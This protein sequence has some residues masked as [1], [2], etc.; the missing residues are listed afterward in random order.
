[1][2]TGRRRSCRDIGLGLLTVLACK[3]EPAEISLVA[4][5]LAPVT[6][7]ITEPNVD[8][9]IVS[10]ADVHMETA[11]FSDPDPGHQH[12][13]SDWAISRASNAE[14]VWHTDCIGGA[15]KLHTHL[16]DGLFVGS[17]AGRRDFVPETDFILRVRHRDSSGDP[18]TEWSEWAERRFRT[19]RALAGG[20]GWLVRQPDFA[21]ERFATGFQLP[22][23]IA[24]L[25]QPGSAADAP[26][27][28]VA[29][30]YGTIK[31][32]TRHG[33]VSDYATNLLNFDPGGIF[34]GSGEQGLAG[35]VVS[36]ATGD[37]FASM[38][39]DAG[40][41]HFPKVVRLWSTDGGRTAAGQQTIL[42][43]VGEAQ[44]QSHQISNLTI[45]PDGKLYV[46][47]GDGFSPARAQDLSSFRGKILRVNLDGSA[48]ADNPFYSAADGINARDY[49]WAY[50]FR[51]P[52]G[53]NWWL[54]N[55]Q[56]WEVENGPSVD[57]LAL[58]KP[59]AN[60]GWNGTDASMLIGASHN[61]DPSVAPIN[62]VF[63]Q[64]GVFGGSG[65][66][67]GKLDHAF[68]SESGPTWAAGR[69]LN[70]KRISEFVLNADGSRASGPTPLV[71]YAGAGKSTVAG[72]AAGPDGLY[73]TDLY[74]EDDFNNPT[75]R[76]ANV[77]RLRYVGGAPLPPPTPPL[78]PPTP[79]PPTPRRRRRRPSA[80]PACGVTTTT[81]STSPA[82]SSRAPTPPST[83]NG[84][85]V[86]RWRVSVA[87]RSRCG[88]RGRS[89]RDSQRPIR[90]P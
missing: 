81:T 28:Y 12:L 10:G 71:E 65:F 61:W 79:P 59:G 89:S 7:T 22:V 84:G 19:D 72:L 51:N 45:G 21:L 24:F 88:G 17:H 1:M 34:P 64:S 42:D 83:S 53:G 40:G 49:V 39:Y 77:L 54:A 44:G 74:R 63:I 27:F 56:H 11:P 86:P 26:F 75:A 2:R 68:V 36:P 60:F 16:G 3:A 50:G 23:N 4:A 66:P 87:T 78:P 14:L 20:A 29:E 52:F 31:V 35:I 43:M 15:E 9:K 76:G 90:S 82:R 6:P 80:L 33:G 47:V 32:V 69:Q 41:P 67:A 70:G 62:I 37:L 13:C 58:V 57:R 30:L 8:G 73:F 85:P 18:A 5:A 55:G 25:P 38:L 48:P 46:H